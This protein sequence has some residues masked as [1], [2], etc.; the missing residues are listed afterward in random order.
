MSKTECLLC[1]SQISKGNLKSHQKTKKCKDI[2]NILT[3]EN[4]TK[5]TK[6]IEELK[7]PKVEPTQEE[8]SIE[9]VHEQARKLGIL[10]DADF[11]KRFEEKLFFH[12][13]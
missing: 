7:K 13:C 11:D 12:G 4:S 10:T 1:R 2:S 6:E 3:K 9:Q 8:L 5:E